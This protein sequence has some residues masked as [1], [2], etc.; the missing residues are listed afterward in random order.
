MR[1]TKPAP[2]L[3]IVLIEP[4]IPWNTGNVGRTCLALGAELVIVGRPGFSLEERA[5]RRSGMDYWPEV[6]LKRYKTWADFLSA[7]PRR[8]LFLFSAGARRDVWEADFSQGGSLI[9]GRESTGIPK[10][11]LETYRDRTYRIPMEAGTRSLN[12]STAV[13]MAL[14]EGVRQNRTQGGI[15]HG[16]VPTRLLEQNLS[17]PLLPESEGPR[18]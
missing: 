6:N 3:Q 14:Y 7:N 5:I 16:K 15:N 8:L 18:G 13:G 2:S 17:F 10:D 1:S 9:F 12:L 11:V 4:E